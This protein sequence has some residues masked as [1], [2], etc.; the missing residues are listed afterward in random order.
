MSVRSLRSNLGYLL[1]GL[2]FFGVAANVSME[3]AS[4]PNS[5]ANTCQ[6]TSIQ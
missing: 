2:I 6:S 4:A 3:I 1:A 5:E